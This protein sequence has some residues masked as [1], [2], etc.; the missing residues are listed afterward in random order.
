[1]ETP[2]DTLTR[3]AAPP[4]PAA[5]AAPGTQEGFQVS[6]AIRLGG[7]QW[8]GLGVLAL[9]IFIFAPRLW[10][11]VE[12]LRLAPDYRVPYELASDYWWYE[13]VAREAAARQEV[14]L[15]GDSVVWGQYVTRDQTLSHYLNEQTGGGPQGGGRFANLGLDGAHP[16]AL[17]GLIEFHGAAL[18]GKKVLLQ[19]NPLWISAPKLDLEEKDEFR[20]NHPALVPQFSPAIP[21][22]REEV[23]RRIGYVLERNLSFFTWVGHLQLACY[24]QMSIPEWSQEHPYA[25][26]LTPLWR[27]PVLEDRA[28]EKPIPWTQRHIDAQDFDWVP[29]ERSF[30]WH[31]FR[32]AVDILRKRN[33]QVFVIVGP[34]NTHLVREASRAVYAER[35]RAMTDELARAGVACLAPEVL[36]SPLYGDASHPLA[37]G[38]ALLA[39]NLLA[40]RPFADFAGLR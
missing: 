2:T 36:P 38:Y 17:A 6:N 34:F 4:S 27:R 35:T 30:Q 37:A 15:L 28:H 29:L 16:A 11:Y 3:A 25:N 23:S 32:R 8:V 20:F 40:S 31:A 10:E 21:C 33:N 1:M 39:Q 5:P 18:T 9:L 19:C 7:R 22:Y 13:R 24:G 14:L 12:P 26:P